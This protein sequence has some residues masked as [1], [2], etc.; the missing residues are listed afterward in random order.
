MS[1]TVMSRVW[2]YS[3][4]S[5]SALLVLLAIADY[6]RD[7]GSAWP[8]IT[9]LAEKARISER[10]TIRII[11]KLERSEELRVTHRR[12]A[13]NFYMIAMDILSD[14]MTLIES[15]ED[16]EID[17]ESHI[18]SDTAESVISDT[19]E[20]HDPSLTVKEPLIKSASDQSN[21]GVDEES[22]EDSRII[23]D[24]EV[25]EDNITEWFAQRKKKMDVRL[26]AEKK[27]RKR[28]T[29]EDVKAG[30]RRAVIDNV[31]R[32]E[33][34]SKDPVV[35]SFLATVPEHVRPLARVF[36]EHKKRPPL[37]NENSMWRREWQDQ[38]DIGL[39]PKDVKRAIKYMGMNNLSVR[40]PV[41]TLTIAENIRLG[42][43][44]PDDE[45][46]IKGEVSYNIPSKNVVLGDAD[47]VSLMEEMVEDGSE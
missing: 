1:I 41:S 25:N 44:K 46:Q 8:S 33:S 29:E 28:H 43:I 10:Q 32:N 42:H 18:I 21:G 4:H 12:H 35:E 20:S 7:D 15:E 3:Q 40:S 39:S 24:D 19:I 23:S 17:A 45:K 9:T 27:E 2:K 16:A 6:A 31:V 30:I 38:Y 36:C 37:K 22:S 13:G 5:G 34:E 26:G 14:R 11:K 47:E